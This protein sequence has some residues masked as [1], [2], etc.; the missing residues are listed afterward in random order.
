MDLASFSIPQIKHILKASSLEQDVF[1]A[2]M[3]VKYF[4]GKY[5]I[6]DKGL[7]FERENEG[8]SIILP[9]LM[10]TL[11]QATKVGDQKT[12]QALAGSKTQIIEE[13]DDDDDQFEYSAIQEFVNTTNRLFYGLIT[14]DIQITNEVFSVSSVDFDRQFCSF[15]RNCVNLFEEYKQAKNKAKI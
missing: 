2:L 13:D 14:K 15:D 4:A 3:L 9:E 12:L 8:R 10:E 5:V 6:V 7:M 1:D 11:I